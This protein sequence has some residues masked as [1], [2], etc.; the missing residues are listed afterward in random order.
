MHGLHGN[1]NGTQV[2]NTVPRFT[3]WYRFHGLR[4]KMNNADDLWVIVFPLKDGMQ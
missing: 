3:F 2:T 1:S 4:K